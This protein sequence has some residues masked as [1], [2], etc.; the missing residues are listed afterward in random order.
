[1]NHESHKERLKNYSERTGHKV[2][3][4]DGGVDNESVEQYAARLKTEDAKYRELHHQRRQGETE[5][6][7]KKRM[8]VKT[9]PNLRNQPK[10][11]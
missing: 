7:H 1:M 10:R 9:Q 2:E 3:Y 4:H 6:Q 11:I 5:E 8:D